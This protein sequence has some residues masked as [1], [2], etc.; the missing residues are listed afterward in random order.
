LRTIREIHHFRL[1]TIS[2]VHVGSGEV[3]EP[4][5][6]YTLS[7]GSITII[8]RALLFQ[9]MEELAPDKIDRFAQAIENRKL[10]K[11]LSS[12]E[13]VRKSLRYEN[14][15][16]SKGNFPKNIRQQIRDAAGRPLIPGSSLKGA[17]RT[18]IVLALLRMAG[19]KRLH[20]E[21]VTA[22]LKKGG[23]IKS[24][25]ADNALMN[26]LLGDDPKNNLMRA[27]TV[28]DI[29][30]G[31]NS[32]VPLVA[33]TTRL[34]HGGKKFA[35]KPFCMGIESLASGSIS[36]GRLSIDRHLMENDEREGCFGFRSSMSLR[37][38]M[39]A[40][41]SRTSSLIDDELEFL[42]DKSGDNLE[43]LRSSY[44][45]LLRLHDSLGE[46]EVIMNL[47]WGIGWRGMTGSVL[48]QDDLNLNNLRAKLNLAVKYSEFPFPKSRRIALTSKGVELLGW[49]RMV[50]CDEDEYRAAVGASQNVLDGILSDAADRSRK[51]AERRGEEERRYADRLRREKAREADRL[52]QKFEDEKYPWRKPLRRLENV[53][54]WG[55]FKQVVLENAELAMFRE[56]A[57]VAS[58]VKKLAEKV[59]SK[60]QSNWE[61]E[62]DDRIAAWLETADVTWTPLAKGHSTVE[63]AVEVSHEAQ[64][65]SSLK[66]WGAFKNKQFELAVLPSDAL[67]ILR[68]KLSEWGCDCK[69][70]KPDK[71]ETWKIVNQLLK[72][73][74]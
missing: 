25:L 34:T 23:K 1:E 52:R 57:E 22:I 21:A 43:H 16:D 18:A 45:S 55:A 62:R 46:N 38:L 71:K 53:E 28:T 44:E 6:D 64:V 56:I 11:E 29:A 69:G 70:V 65:I 72:T 48:S 58:S 68:T 63:D 3:Y 61:G 60:W 14:P 30:F 36:Y 5:L 4:D 41:R 15:F 74:L 35:D 51:L 24:E 19:G 42:N 67:K 7:N 8:N 49:V 39:H 47:G 20:Q 27:L 10:F 32:I 66:D 33:K 73:R 37:N 13:I 50:F 59:R 31:A 26:G 9:N 40:L 17:M 2:P 54:D 12:H